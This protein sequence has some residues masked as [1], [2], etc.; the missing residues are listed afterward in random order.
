MKDVEVYTVEDFE[1]LKELIKN[2]EKYN[3]LDVEVQNRASLFDEM[4]KNKDER[5]K[6]AI[7]KLEENRIDEAKAV[8]RDDKVIVTLK[9]EDVI[10][11]RFIFRDSSVLNELGITR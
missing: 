6:Y 11:I 3:L 4:L 5:L 9:I 1:K 10:S 2:V 7:E 8:I